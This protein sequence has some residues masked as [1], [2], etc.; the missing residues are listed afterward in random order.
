MW[1]ARMGHIS[2]R[3]LTEL[4]KQG[5]IRVDKEVD[6]ST[7]EECIMAKSKKLSYE[8]SHNRISKPLDYVHADL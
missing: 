4:T 8:L 6:A 7:C 5:L 1:H 3:G 2:Q